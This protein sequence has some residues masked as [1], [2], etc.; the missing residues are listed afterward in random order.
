MRTTRKALGLTVMTVL[1]VSGSMVAAGPGTAGTNHGAVVSADPADWTP[2]VVDEKVRST[3][4]VDGITVAVGDFDQVREQG[5]STTIARHLVFA[6]D[7][8][9]QVLDQVDPVITGSQAWDVVP[10]GDGRSVFIGGSFSRVDGLARPRVFKM[11]VHTGQ[12]DPT[13]RPPSINNRITT[14]ELR[15]GR[16]YAGGYFTQVG[17]VARTALV[18]LDPTTGADTG[19]VGVTVAGTWNGG[20]MRVEEMTLNPAGTRLVAI[21]NFR[22]VNGQERNQI[23]MLDLGPTSA[24]LSPWSTRGYSNKCSN[25]FETYMYDVD[26]SPD[27][28]YFVVVTTG[29][30]SGGPGAGS[31]CDAAARFEFASAAPNQVPTWVE[32]SGG[33]TF[34]AVEVTDEAIYVG[35]HFRWMNN[36]YAADRLGPGALSRKGLAALD[37]RNGL[38]LT[39]NPG[40]DRGWGVWGFRSTPDGLWVGH[41]TDTVA[42]ETHGKL[43][44]FPLAGGTTMPADRSGTLPGDVYLMG[45]PGDATSGQRTG[46]D[47]A[48]VTST[49][50]QGGGGTDWSTVRGG[51]MLDGRLFYGLADGTFKSRTFDGTRFGNVGAVNLYRNTGFAGELPSV[52]SMFYDRVLGRMYFTLAGSTRLYYRYFTSES[53]VVG[54]IRY[55]VGDPGSGVTWNTVTGAFLVGDRLYVRQG[56][57]LARVSWQS[58]APVAGSRAVVSGPAVDGGDWSSRV[59]FLRAP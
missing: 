20:V 58:G 24:T 7:S 4:T 53:R 37:P 41:D 51:F 1:V 52:T 43:A 42:G 16:L 15:N 27:G 2:H 30:Y 21:G 28:Q 23:F 22:S 5:S 25:T 40:R 59:M 39:W 3:A 47:G 55:E 17:G 50:P 6:F 54:G 46:F 11:D 38:P 33:D 32:Y 12:V 56:T 57:T 26:S 29:A 45:R 18:A 48:S 19:T 44:F 35:G 13:F 34:T 8:S 49:A 14:L 36:P 10:A 31:L 9:G